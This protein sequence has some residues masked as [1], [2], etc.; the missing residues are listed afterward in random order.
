ME[1]L[2]TTIMAV[3]LIVVLTIPVALRLWSNHQCMHRIRMWADEQGYAVIRLKYTYPFGILGALLS[4]TAG[5]FEPMGLSVAIP[6]GRTSTKK[7]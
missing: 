4:V 7:G 1:L 6:S 3:I 5:G 2:Y